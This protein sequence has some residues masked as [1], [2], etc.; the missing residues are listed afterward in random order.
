LAIE[1]RGRH[2]TGYAYIDDGA[3]ELVKA[4]IS[5]RDFVKVAPMFTDE[6]TVR[7]RAILLHTRYATQGSPSINQNNHPIHS[8]VSGLTL[9]HNGWLTNEAKILSKYNLTKDAA[10]DS[11]TVLRLIEFFIE[12]KKKRIITAIRLA[13]KELRGVF[14]CALISAKYPDTV[15]L[16]RSGNP[17]HTYS[18]ETTGAFVFASTFDLLYQA[19]DGADMTGGRYVEFAD[20]KVAVLT[21]KQEKLKIEIGDLVAR[22]RPERKKTTRK[23]IQRSLWELPSKRAD[24]KIKPVHFDCPRCRRDIES[25]GGHIGFCL[26]CKHYYDVPDAQNETAAAWEAWK[27][28][29]KKIDQLEID[30]ALIHANLARKNNK[31]N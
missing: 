18:C 27:E 9:I 3:T 12:K 2:A 13:M 24:D 29:G 31:I 10:V 1:R 16:W 26:T 28:Q 23:P 11:E 15:W 19:I 14:A 25:M 5:A 22:P 17:L 4:D 8:K 7:P 20:H 30:A 21:V 6:F